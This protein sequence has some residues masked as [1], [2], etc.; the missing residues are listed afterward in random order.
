M[1]GSSSFVPAPLAPTKSGLTTYVFH[2]SAV[3]PLADEELD[4]NGT[5]SS[6][7]SGRTSASTLLARAPPTEFR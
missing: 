6:N 3:L 4:R 1:G 2:F 5:T 7:G